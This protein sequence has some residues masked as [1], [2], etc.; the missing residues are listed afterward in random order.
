MKIV[1]APLAVDRMEEAVRFIAR[2]KPD[3]ARSWAEQL[4]AR[5]D[6]LARFPESGRIVPEL[7]RDDIREI[8]HVSHRIIYRVVGSEVRIVTVRHA[9]RLVDEDELR[10]S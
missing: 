1:W 8:V 9:A 10:G 2:D 4:L 5:V 7:D 6:R 3:A